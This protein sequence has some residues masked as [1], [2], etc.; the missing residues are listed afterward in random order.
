MSLVDMRSADSSDDRPGS[1]KSTVS[2]KLAKI[3]HGLTEIWISVGS[4]KHTSC[5]VIYGIRIRYEAKVW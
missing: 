1:F 5:I 4:Q 2:G 3:S